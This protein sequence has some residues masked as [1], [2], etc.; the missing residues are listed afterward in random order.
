MKAR[1]EEA[2]EAG[3]GEELERE[4][5]N[6]KHLE[7]C[8]EE[9]TAESNEIL[10][11]LRLFWE[12]GKYS[13]L[14]PWQCERQIS[15]DSRLCLLLASLK[16]RIAGRYHP[17]LRGTSKTSLLYSSQPEAKC[18]S[19]PRLLGALCRETGNEGHQLG[20]SLP[21]VAFSPG[22][23]LWWGPASVVPGCLSNQSACGGLGCG[24]VGRA[25]V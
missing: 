13:R 4:C 5:L 15:E 24:S 1:R 19:A 10:P 20:L 12:W 22:A 9:V 2:P 16:N 6:C 14:G 18:I 3:D 17:K 8:L 25:L 11:R 23:W 7:Y 21:W